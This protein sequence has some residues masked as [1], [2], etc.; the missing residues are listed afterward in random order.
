MIQT[1]RDNPYRITGPA[2]ISFSGGRTSAY[3]LWRFLQEN[4]GALPP[5]VIVAFANT[6]KER[7]ETLRFVHEC[8]SRWN[9]PIVWLEWR[10]EGGFETVSYNSA[11]RKG[12]PFAELIAHKQ[13]LPN[14]QERWCTEFLKVRTIVAYLESLG[15]ERWINV[16]GLRFDEKGRVA[17][18]WE[19]NAAT[20]EKWQ[21]GLPAKSPWINEMPLYRSGVTKAHVMDFWAMQPFDLGLM[22]HEGNCDGCFLKGVKFLREIFRADPKSADW[23]IEQESLMGGTFSKR[24]SYD[25]LLQAVLAQPDLFF[26]PDDDLG[27][28]DVECG[29]TC[30]VE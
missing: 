17:K 6:G 10:K 26:M 29:D 2:V 7:E 8:G 16:V 14:W 21:Q 30:E 22:P 19:K 13:R 4:G 11:S 25:G 28:Y 12:E 18:Q 1:P 20:E 3:M 9:V 24:Y 27:D 23:W 5:G 15:W